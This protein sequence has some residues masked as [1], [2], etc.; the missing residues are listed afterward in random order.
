MP[1]LGR[2]ARSRRSTG[3]WPAVRAGE[4]RRAGPPRR[5]GRGQVGAARAPRASARRV[6]RGARVGRAVRDGAR[7]RRP[8]PAVRAAAATAWSGC[9]RR[10]RARCGRR[11]ASA[12]ER[13]RTASSSAWRCSSLL[14]EAAEE[15][16]L[17]CVVDDAQWLD[18][19]SAEALAFV[20]RRLLAESVALVF[21]ARDSG[22]ERRAGR[23]AGADDRRPPRTRRADAARHGRRR[24][25]GRAG[26]RSDRRRDA[27]Q[28]AGAAR[29]AARLARP[30]SWPA[31]SRC[32]MRRRCRAASRSSFR[33]RLGA[34]PPGTRRLLLV[35]AAEPSGDS[36]LVLRAAE[37]L[38]LGPADAATPAREAGLLEL[39]PARAA[40]ASARPF[41]G[42]P[43]RDARGAPAACTRRWRSRPIPSVDPDRRAW[44]R[45]QSA[46]GP[47]AEIAAELERSAGRAQ[48]RGGYAAAA[49][50]LE[51]TAA[52]NVD[53]ERRA[54][55]ALAAAEAKHRAGA[56]D[57]ALELLD[58]RR[59]RA[60]G[61]APARAR[62]SAARPDRVRAEPRPRR[63]GAAGSRPRSGSSRSTPRSPRRRTGTRSPPR[64][65]PAPGRR[66]RAARRWHRRHAKR[67]ASALARAGLG[68]AA[69]RG[70]AADHRRLRGRRADRAARAAAR[71]SPT[72]AADGDAVSW[73]WF[74]CR[75]R[76]RH[77]GR[78][79][80]RAA[81]RRS[82]V[83]LV[84]DAGAL[85]SLPF[86]LEHP[87]RRAPVRRR[88]RR[89]R[90]GDR[91]ARDGRRRHGQRPLAVRRHRARRRCGAAKPRPRAASDAHRRRRAGTRRRAMAGGCGLGA[92]G[93][94]QRPR[95]YGAALAAAEEVLA[96]PAEITVTDWALPELIEAATPQ[97]PARARTR[98]AR[99]ARGADARRR[100]R[101][102][103]GVV[104]AVAGADERRRRRGARLPRGRRAPGPHPGQGLPGPCASALRR[105]AAP[106]APAARRAR[107]TAH[108]ARACS[109]RSGWRPSR[110]ARRASC[111]RPA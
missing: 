110:S 29:A 28:S 94:L 8:A 38:G 58:E 20:A 100:Q 96:H 79:E 54:E 70:G 84:R 111:W 11:S 41:G 66:R 55:R 43:C 73:L 99:A 1:L 104:R 42:L 14:S 97:R 22:A 18:R 103:L 61:R 109:W 27:R 59:G 91:R 90:L 77:L 69:G 56:P 24:A 95:P 83:A 107:A 65:T 63:S 33:R 101:L 26:A 64:G 32:R 92:R 105:V 51:R 89:G 35:A 48:A 87:R 3:C 47:D 31:A 49:A 7:V 50:F 2:G 34:L 39:G 85:S 4:S 46:A 60:A 80:L 44:H 68:S 36:A 25:A 71:S 21:A 82:F 10:S 93:A 53:P 13:R 15:R 12:R 37:R 6:P 88:V 106:R 78:R 57:A 81:G 19:A 5:A 102:G 67:R 98:R 74:A 23:A 108:R 40:P 30:P 76:A 86:A 45:A 52:L 16:P 17:V 9:R 75:A 72:P 62:G